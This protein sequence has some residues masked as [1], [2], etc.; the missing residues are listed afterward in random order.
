MPG[1]FPATRLAEN[2]CK[3]P[4]R[5]LANP[6]REAY[7]WRHWGATAIELVESDA[8]L[9][10]G[11]DLL[12]LSG[13]ESTARRGRDRSRVADDRPG[14]E[15]EQ[16]EGYEPERNRSVSGHFAQLIDSAG[17]LAPTP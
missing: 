4:A 12:W 7:A 16:D 13:K 2:P 15:T 6:L 3:T 14:S 5:T 9:L 8:K 1:S 17:V 11:N 10:Q